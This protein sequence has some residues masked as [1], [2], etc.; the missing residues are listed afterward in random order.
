MTDDPAYEMYHL[1]RSLVKLIDPSVESVGAAL[2][3]LADNPELR[4]AMAAYS[5]LYTLK[6]FEL[7][8]NVAQINA[9]LA[10]RKIRVLR[11]PG[12]LYGLIRS[13]P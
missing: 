3:S 12:D 2:Q 6:N 10:A 8:T 13:H 7:A 11:L 4:E 1:D 9:R 5:R